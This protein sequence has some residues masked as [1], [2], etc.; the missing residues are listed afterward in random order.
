M[1]NQIIIRKY[2]PS[3]AQ[4]I[5]HIYYHTIHIINSKDYSEEQINAWAPW[6]SVQDYS[7]WSEKL[8]RIKPLVALINGSIVGFVEFEDNGHIDCFYV[9]HLH[10]GDGIGKALM[11]EI[12]YNAETM[13]I[14]R[15]YAEVSITAR[16]FFESRGFIVVK[17]QQVYIR[18]VALTN[19]IMEKTV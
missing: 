17:E 8:A 6:S 12:V 10:Q 7:G 5:A 18:G 1:N 3:D 9:H 16:P 13:E 4:E 2:I 14:N 19:F 11:Y 15:I